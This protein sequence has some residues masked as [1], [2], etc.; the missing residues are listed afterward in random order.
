MKKKIKNHLNQYI[1]EV[2]ECIQNLDISNLTKASQLIEKTIKKKNK[3]FVCGNGG[4]ASISNHFI[5]DYLKLIRTNTKLKPKIIS[6]SNN[7]ETITAISNDLNYE[8]IFLFQAESLYEQGDIFIII[9]SSGNSKNIIKLARWCK[10]KKIK[11]ICFTGFD[12]GSLKK[13]SNFALVS[14]SKKYGVVEDSHQILM[15][16]IM[17]YIILKNKNIK[18]PRL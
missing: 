9:S 5:C 12:G 17:H 15:H 16:F 3:I 1:S 14:K 8:D 2:T 11:T 18:K 13:I 7:I 6:L 10:K 4:S